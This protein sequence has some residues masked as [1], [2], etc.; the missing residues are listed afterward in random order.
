[1]NRIV[2]VAPPAPRV[3]T[4]PTVPPASFSPTAVTARPDRPSLEPRHEPPAPEKKAPRRRT[5]HRVIAVSLLV[6]G[7]MTASLAEPGPRHATIV[8][9]RASPKRSDT[10]AA[11]RWW[12]N[13][14]KV[15]LDASVGDIGA[16]AEDAVRG[17]FGTWL[18]SGENLPRL[19][20]D[21]SSKR[22][23]VTL[24][25]DGENR[26]YFAPIAVP[27]HENDL[28]ITLAYTR[29]DT[30]EVTE[31]DLVINAKHAFAVLQT[32]PAG[33]DRD[34]DRD[35]DRD[36]G[37]DEGRS[38]AALSSDT[39]TA[40]GCESTYDVQSV[41]T[42]EVGHFFGL[43]EDTT[44]PWATMYYS[45]TPCDLGKRD[46]AAGD[47]G[48]M[49]T[50]YASGVPGTGADPEDPGSAVAASC[51]MGLVRPQ[52]PA[53]ALGLALALA[54]GTRLRRTRR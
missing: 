46:L 18:A 50:L 5:T 51:A 20:F 41:L 54:V 8:S 9:G 23:P 12:R 52:S 31:T 42:H 6:L 15:T 49:S 44:D 19:D 33:N 25:P 32:Q 30:G 24:T 17:A 3:V 13:E 16:G 53:Q 28:A 22:R 35:R 27:G 37:R 43:G 48:E 10:G 14:V 1:L 40:P 26:V 34:G 21:W 7:A 47:S 36:R 38:S 4:L 39:A 2:P 29:S 11:V 45:T